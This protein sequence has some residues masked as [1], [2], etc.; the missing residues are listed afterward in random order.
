M[1]RP[2]PNNLRAYTPKVHKTDQI[3]KIWKK[4]T[5]INDIFQSLYLV[6]L[7]DSIKFNFFSPHIQTLKH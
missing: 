4:Y 2:V 7:K 3:K 1:W 5:Y 6:F